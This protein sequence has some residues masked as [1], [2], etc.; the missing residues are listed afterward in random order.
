M[1]YFLETKTILM[2]RVLDLNLKYEYQNL[3]D[4]S[5]IE[6]SKYSAVDKCIERIT[7]GR[8]RYEEVSSLTMVPWFFIGIIH[9]MECSCNFKTH[10]HNGDPLTK[11]T[12]HVPK[13]RPRNGVPPFTWE[14]SA[15]DALCMKG[16]DKWTDWSIPAMLFQFERFNG[17]GYRSR[18][19]YSPYLWSFSNHYKKGK[20][21]S[22][23]VY[24]PGAVSKQIGAAVLLRRLYEKQVETRDDADIISQVKKQGSAVK[25]NSKKYNEAAAELQRLLNRSGQYLKIDGFAGRN[26]SDAFFRVTG[27]YLQQ[28]PRLVV[29]SG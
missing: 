9:N 12:V 18:G 6:L 21:T 25:F 7:A 26:T 2:A 11:R 5:I 22:D 13:D 14:E 10:L 16:L 4:T 17:F 19:I 15:A 29:V 8:S 24:D 23:G 27:R 1:K 28:D 3:F 20:F